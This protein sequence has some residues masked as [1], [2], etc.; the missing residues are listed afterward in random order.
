MKIKEP[1]NVLNGLKF[2]K[3][4]FSK[5]H[6]IKIDAYKNI[7]NITKPFTKPISKIF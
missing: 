1:V 3:I 5:N 6:L 7:D 4:E 2:K